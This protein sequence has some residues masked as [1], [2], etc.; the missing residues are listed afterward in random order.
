MKA[1]WSG[2][3]GGDEQSAGAAAAREDRQLGA[4]GGADCRSVPATRRA[5]FL[6]LPQEPRPARIAAA[7][8]CA[9]A[10]RAV[11]AA[12]SRPHQGHS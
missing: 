9:V 11:P 8:P 7:A 6:L 12:Q 4:E 10:A 2:M 3:G 5:H 1:T